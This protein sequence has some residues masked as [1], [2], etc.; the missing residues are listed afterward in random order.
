M[1]CK[2]Y[3]IKTVKNEST[4][5][6]GIKEKTMKGLGLDYYHSLIVGKRGMNFRTLLIQYESALC[7]YENEDEMRA[8]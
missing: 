3:I 8:E 1:I 6:L 7:R 5:V 2:L 4:I